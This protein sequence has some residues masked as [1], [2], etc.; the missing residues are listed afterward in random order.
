M[1][2]LAIPLAIGAAC[3]LL[4]AVGCSQTT[5]GATPFIEPCTPIDESAVDPCLR[6]PFWQIVTTT[7]ASYSRRSIP[8]LPIDVYSRIK[9]THDL[10]DVGLGTTQ[11]YVRG[12][13]VP[14][15][16][17]CTQATTIMTAAEPARNHFPAKPLMAGSASGD[18][19]VHFNCFVDLRVNEYFNGNGP[20]TI[21]LL[22][23][24]LGVDED[25]RD[26]YHSSVLDGWPAYQYEGKEMIVALRRGPDISVGAWAHDFEASWDVQR[27]D[28]GKVVVV[29]SWV[30]ILGVDDPS[31]WEYTLEEFRPMVKE[32][33][34]RFRSETNGRVGDDPSDPEFAKD[35]SGAS[36]I[37]HL[38]DLGAFTIDDITPAPAPTVPGETDPD[39]YGY[40]ANEDTI[41]ASAEDA[42]T[43]DTPVPETHG[44][45]R[46]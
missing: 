35:A 2:R 32:A 24:W 28:D 30:G 21:P 6:D 43:T 39:P 11:F 27:R 26:S 20:T 34:A 13:F 19:S 5:E 17:R 45:D 44:P 33:M 1:N 10:Y 8:K 12:T 41:T 29:S 9:R 40:R 14:D 3:S 46:Q 18:G 42:T 23:F 37:D 15:S 7:R 4:I 25:P 31:Q 38:R 22:V 36:Y 16:A